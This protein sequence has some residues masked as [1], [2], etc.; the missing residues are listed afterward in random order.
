MLTPGPAVMHGVSRL[1]HPHSLVNDARID[2]YK[3]A[4]H[5]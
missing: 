4:L 2:P 5:V 3:E 1:D